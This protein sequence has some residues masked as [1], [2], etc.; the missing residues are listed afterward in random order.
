MCLKNYIEC[1][2]VYGYGDSVNDDSAYKVQNSRQ[3]LLNSVLS[4]ILANEEKNNYYSTKKLINYL[5]TEKPDLL[6]LHNLHDYHNVDI[7]I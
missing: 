1:E 3:Y 4:R 5:K 6:H 2:I 7:E